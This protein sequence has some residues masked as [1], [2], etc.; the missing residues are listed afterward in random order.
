MTDKTSES[1]CTHNCQEYARSSQ[2][3]AF[4]YIH[5]A[6]LPGILITK[7]IKVHSLTEI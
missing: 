7:N 2:K 1:G 6:D 3:H 5:N 4:A